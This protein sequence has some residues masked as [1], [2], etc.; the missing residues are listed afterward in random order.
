MISFAKRSAIFRRFGS[1]AVMIG[2]FFAG[3]LPAFGSGGA[4]LV[5]QHAISAPDGAVGLCAKY[6]WACATSSR[7][8]LSQS[9]K[10]RL[11]SSVNTQ[12][13]LQTT[14]I[15]DHVQYGREE[16]WALPT[17]R[18]G[19]CEDFVLLKKKILIKNGVSA[20]NLLIATVLDRNLNSHAVLI[21]RTQNG[22]LVL[23]NLTNDIHL[24]KDTGYTFLKL[25]SPAVPGG[26]HA[27]MA[28]GVIKERPTAT[29]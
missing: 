11:A 2:M 1:V 9:D 5:A 7:S 17:A 13:N 10:I 25:Q 23:D 6:K 15:D 12:V 28:G 22:D 29:K 19:D 21:L 24:W 3:I 8:S 26:W 14:A 20:K 4:F 18:G 27:V 16:H